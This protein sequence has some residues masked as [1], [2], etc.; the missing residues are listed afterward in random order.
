MES[1]YHSEWWFDLDRLFASPEKLR[2]YVAELAKRFACQQVDAVCGPM[3]GG[4]KLAEL[5]ASHLG[6]AYF[7]AERFEPADA[8][9]MFPVSYKNPAALRAELAGKKV[10]IVDDAMS[11]GSAVRGTFTDVVACRGRPVV[12][13]ALFVFG[14]AMEGFAAE[15]RVPL[16]AIA[17]MEFNFWSP[18]ECPLCRAGRACE[19]ISAR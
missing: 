15:Q 4:A 16:E 13:G 14:A 17:R 10:A 2:P 18:A 5:I 7:F 3:T 12:L 19:K 11:A 1:G 9:G 8:Q 6:T